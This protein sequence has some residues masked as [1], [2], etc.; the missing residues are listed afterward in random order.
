[1]T[2]TVKDEDEDKTHSGDEQIGNS[3]TVHSE[4]KTRHFS[5]VTH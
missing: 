5:H 3:L 1:M 2:E 4:H